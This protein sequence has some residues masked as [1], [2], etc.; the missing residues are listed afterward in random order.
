M[1]LTEPH[2]PAE[3]DDGCDI[4]VELADEAAAAEN[5]KQVV[6][7]GIEWASRQ[8]EELLEVGVPSIHFYVMQ[9]AK[10]VARVMERLAARDLLAQPVS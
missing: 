1:S 2:P 8:V 7:V 5:R 6:E 9:N 4:P 10:A 3:S